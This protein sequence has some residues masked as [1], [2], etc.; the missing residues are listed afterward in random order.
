MSGSAS[1]SPSSP[2]TA[3]TDRR[4]LD[5]IRR[6]R[7][8]PKFT[9]E[10]VPRAV[11]EH[12]LEAATWAPNHHLTEP[13]Q[14][15]VL[16]GDAKAQFADLRRDFRLSL[17]PDPAA[18]AAQAAA[19]KIARDTAAIPVIIVVTTRVSAD[20]VLTEDDYAATMCAMQN[21]LLAAL[22]EGVGTY[23]RT[24][25]LIHDARL[26]AFLALPADRRVAAIVYV[27]YPAVIP[28][29]Q[30]APWTEKTVWLSERRVLKDPVPAAADA[31]G[32]AREGIAIDPVC[33]MEVE[34]AMAVATSIYNGTTYYF[35]APGCKAAFDEDAKAYVG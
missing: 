24:G 1:S 10:P 15:F 32:D 30:R 23:P 4:V 27:G 3:L 25:G 26:R 8:I 35:C 20:P 17:F 18:A 6:R 13:W 34:M 7:S 9:G 12:M 2:T 28:E 16:E 11:I 21:M 29:R 33:K 14:F 31:R 5:L 22:D 19:D